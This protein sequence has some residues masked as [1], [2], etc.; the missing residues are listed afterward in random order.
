MSFIF[1]HQ[2]LPSTPPAPAA[3]PER[4]RARIWAGLFALVLLAAVV[5]SALLF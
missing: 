4:V 2:A 1:D 3:L 5:G